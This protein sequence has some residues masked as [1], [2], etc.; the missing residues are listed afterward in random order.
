LSAC[1]AGNTSTS[2]ID[3]SFD[4]TGTNS[5][6]VI[7]TYTGVPNAYV[8]AVKGSL[9]GDFASNEVKYYFGITGQ[10]ELVENTFNGAIVFTSEVSGTSRY[11]NGYFVT[12]EG[13]NKNGDLLKITTEGLNLNLSG[14]EY[15]SASVVENDG[16]AS[17]VTTGTTFSNLPSGTFTYDRNPVGLIGIGDNLEELSNISVV[18][19]F[20]N[21][22]GNLTAASENLFMSSTG[23]EIDPKTGSF[24]GGISVIGELATTYSQPADVLGAFAGQN[25]GGVH[26]IIYNLSDSVDNGLGVFIVER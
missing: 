10:K 4:K 26:V 23:F 17:L 3:N 16:F 24:S 2:A 12:R 15:M 19:N 9:D 5:V 14:S 8:V 11:T 21:L 6:G 7:K 20:N 1:G 13:I 22:T 18:A 25:A